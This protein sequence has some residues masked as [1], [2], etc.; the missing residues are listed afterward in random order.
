MFGVF[1]R[2]R[3]DAK[4]SGAGNRRDVP[5]VRT[6][7]ALACADWHVQ[8]K[9]PAC[10]SGEKDWMAT[11]ADY[12]LQLSRM[13]L[14][15]APRRDMPL[16]ILVPGDIFDKHNPTPELINWFVHNSPKMYAVPGNHDL[17]NNRLSDLCKSGFW[18]CCL[19]DRIDY[20]DPHQEWQIPDNPMLRL[21]GFPWGKEVLPCPQPH[22]LHLEIALVH[23]YLWADRK[24]G[25]K[26]APPEAN[27]KRMAKRFAGYDVVLVGDNHVPFT[28]KIGN[29]TV[30]NCGSLMRR[31]ADQKDYKPAV[32]VIYNDG[33]V[34]PKYL[35]ISRDVFDDSHLQAKREANAEVGKLAD[36]LKGVHQETADFDEAV[37]RV[38]RDKSVKGSVRQT[39]QELLDEPG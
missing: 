31:T 36:Y 17:P 20:V 25:Y 30:V 38:I 1:G 16:P 24:T 26:D 33:S 5:G 4:G 29:T 15:L 3:K 10:R 8:S 12:L 23:T 27:L 14:S 35:D 13:Q 11:Q 9:A 39:L 32:W 2:G 34:E 22:D 28:A 18:T 6:A 37:K 19:T 7:V 21:W